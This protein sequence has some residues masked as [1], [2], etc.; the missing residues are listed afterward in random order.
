MASKKTSKEK[1]EENHRTTFDQYVRTKYST[2][3]LRNRSN[4]VDTEL[5]NSLM[6]AIK[7]K[8]KGKPISKSL[9]GRIRR[10]K[11]AAIL[12]HGKLI[13]AQEKEGKTIFSYRLVNE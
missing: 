8:K 3:A 12:K 9:D 10:R 2:V 5:A 6:A 11:F 4:V 13:L 7:D 1:D